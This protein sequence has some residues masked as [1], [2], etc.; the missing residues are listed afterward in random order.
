[1]IKNSGEDTLNLNSQMP[2][3]YIFVENEAVYRYWKK[4]LLNNKEIPLKQDVKK[5]G[6][7]RRVKNVLK[8]II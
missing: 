2:E 3:N 5:P 7:I 1:M 8:G 4:L 6:F